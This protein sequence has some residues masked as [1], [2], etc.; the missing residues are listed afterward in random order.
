M[1]TNLF[2]GQILGQLNQVLRFKDGIFAEDTVDITAKRTNTLVNIG[3]KIVQV[4][5]RRHVVSQLEVLDRLAD[6]HDLGGTVGCDDAPLNYLH[7]VSAVEH[8]HI[9]E[10][11]RHG[12]YL[13]HNVVGAEL[14][15]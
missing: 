2:P 8:A 11:Q 10:I 14:L 1:N 7:G 5:Y 4:K 13:D 6:S 3:I 12:V 9:A 15:G